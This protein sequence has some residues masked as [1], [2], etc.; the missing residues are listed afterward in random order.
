MPSRTKWIGHPYYLDSLFTYDKLIEHS[1]K[2]FEAVISFPLWF[3]KMIG[4]NFDA[5]LSK[6]GYN[7]VSDLFYNNIRENC[8]TANDVIIKKK[9]SN[10]KNKL[11]Q[12]IKNIII[13]NSNKVFVIH[14]LQ[15]NRY[16]N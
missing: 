8:T 1:P 2:S 11:D 12:S 5:Q 16:K 15:T 3:N 9:I 14:P 7:F 13:E 6:S 4:T 10:L